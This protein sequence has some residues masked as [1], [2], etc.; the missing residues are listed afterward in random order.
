MSI[1]KQIV[2]ISLISFSVSFCVG[3]VLIR[4]ISYN[5]KPIHPIGYYQVL[6]EL[7]STFSNIHKENPS[8][9]EDDTMTSQRQAVTGL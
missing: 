4:Y 6:D 2:I 1:F 8:N 9:M 5:S 7:R 3:T